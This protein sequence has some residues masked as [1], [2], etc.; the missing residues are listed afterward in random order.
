MNW[1]KAMIA[2]P[3]SIGLLVPTFQVANAHD[4]EEHK[5]SMSMEVSTPAS[6]LRASLDALLSE[7]AFLA[8]VAMQK[9]VDGAE[10]FDQAAAALNANADDLSAAV[11]SVYGEEGG[12]AFKEIWSSHIGY[13]VD[14]VTATAEKDEE[15]KKQA[16]AELDEYTVEQAEFLDTATESRLKADELQEGLKMHVEQLIWAFDHYVEG[17]YDEA[18]KNLRHAIEHMYAPGKGLSWAITDQFPDKFENTTVDTPAADLR[19]DLNHVFAEHAALAVLAMQK[20]IDGAEDFDNAAGALNENTDDLSAAV[21]SVYG[22]EGG[23]AFNEIWSSHIGYFVDYVV[24]TGEEN[25]EGREEAVAELE[26][27]KVEQAA[28]LETATEGRL[29]GADLEKGLQMHV[30]ELLLAFNSYNEGDYE[31]TYNTFREAYSHMFGV[32]E[33]M[34]GAIVDQFP[35]KFAAEKGEEMP[36][37][38]PNTGMGGGSGMNM[39]ALLG[40]TVAGIISAMVL[41]QVIRRKKATQ[42]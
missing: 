40:W 36:S 20:G 4:H 39:N 21:A 42:E 28:F 12:A 24:A 29:K 41:L 9:G 11:A 7:H 34:S 30:D 8:V 22:E 15:G 37:E 13:F 5:H 1:K 35:D 17:N 25:E 18:Y 23:A 33:M 6:D 2:V 19:A 38:M 14:Y 32:G 16:L 10:D 3:L 27:Y 31:T 26:E